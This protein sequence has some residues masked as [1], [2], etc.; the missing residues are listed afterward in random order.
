MLLDLLKKVKH[1]SSKQGKRIENIETLSDF[2][3]IHKGERCFIVGNGPSLTVDDLNRLRGEYT[4]GVNKVY[5]CFAKTKWR[6]TYFVIQDKKMILQ[7]KDELA[8]AD[9]P[10]K[11]MPD[12]LR[13]TLDSSIGRTYY[14]PYVTRLYDGTAAEFSLSPDKQMFEGGTVAYCCLQLALYMGFSQVYLL[15]VDMNYSIQNTKDGLEVQQVRDYF[16]DGYIAKDEDRNI[17]NIHFSLQSYQLAKK[18]YA[19]HGASIYNATRG[20][21]LELF[22][23]VDLHEVLKTKR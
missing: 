8:N 7:C 4:F 17:P 16:V 3:D 18:V 9:L 21:K 2:Q 10:V 11:F 1:P 23:R 15:G 12:Y 5:L 13:E 19:N 6:P 22:E 14:Y 20:G